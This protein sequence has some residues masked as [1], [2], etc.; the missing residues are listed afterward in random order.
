MRRLETLEP[1]PQLAQAPGADKPAKMSSWIQLVD[2]VLSPAGPDAQSWWLRTTSVANDAYSEYLATPKLDRPTVTVSARC[3]P[4]WQ[5]IERFLRPSLLKLLTPECKAMQLRKVYPALE[6]QDY[7]LQ[8]V[9]EYHQAMLKTSPRFSSRSGLR[10][11]P[12]QRLMH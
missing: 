10:A 3:P 6:L 7:M 11:H 4:R 1:I 12:P 8:A 9:I 5:D 2:S